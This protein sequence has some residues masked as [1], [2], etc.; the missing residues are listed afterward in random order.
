MVT[1]PWR[2]RMVA[3]AA[4]ICTAAAL[5]GCSTSGAATPAATGP[6]NVW[7]RGAGDSAKAY[8]AIFDK[9]TTVTGIPITPFFTLTDFETKL[10][11]A[12]TSHTLPDLVVDD[13]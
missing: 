9:F 5:S 3:A 4:A 12:A 1:T 7:V 10:S 8:Q 6:L 2:Q 11:A 13:A